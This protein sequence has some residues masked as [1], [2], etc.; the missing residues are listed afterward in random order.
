VRMIPMIVYGMIDLLMS[1]NMFAYTTKR[2][3]KIKATSTRAEWWLRL[4]II[5]MVLLVWAITLMP[6]IHIIL[7]D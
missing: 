1:W 2:S 5:A 6:V 3:T 4:I 7:H